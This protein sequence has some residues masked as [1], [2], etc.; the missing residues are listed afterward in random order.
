V[1]TAGSPPARARREIDLAGAGRFAGLDARAL[2]AWLAPLLEA[3]AP[4][5]ASLAVR[6]VGERTMRDFN[7]DFR[8]QDRPTD[9]LSFPGEESPE[10][11]HLGDVLVCV[12]VARRQAAERGSNLAREARVLILHGLLHC[13]G[14]DHEADEG[15]ME[16][17]ER[18]LRRRWIDAG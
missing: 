9:V 16:R 6:F 1:R 14:Y 15:R 12:P 3:V 17:L 13:L 11:R 5:G 7:R 10:G 2:R 8:G 18:R 4:G